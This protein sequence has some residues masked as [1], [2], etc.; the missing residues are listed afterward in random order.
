MVLVQG[1]MHPGEGQ[2]RPAGQKRERIDVPYMCNR[3]IHLAPLCVAAF[4]VNPFKT[5][6]AFMGTAYL[7]FRVWLFF[8]K[9]KGEL[10]HIS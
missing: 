9:Q 6:H 10:R 3:M 2:H 8:Q 5:A 4:I 1:R 7:G